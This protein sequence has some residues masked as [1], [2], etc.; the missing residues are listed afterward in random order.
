[1]QTHHFLHTSNASNQLACLL[2]ILIR[3]CKYDDL[4]FGSRLN[5]MCI[6]GADDLLQ[7]IDPHPLF[8]LNQYKIV[9]IVSYGFTWR[10]LFQLKYNS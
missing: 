9:L 3:S 5:N 1:M 10:A 8:D 4:S 6:D 7:K 2:N